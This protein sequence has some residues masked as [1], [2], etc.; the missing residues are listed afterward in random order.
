M[1]WF[2]FLILLL[3]A[4]LTALAVWWAIQKWFRDESESVSE[5]TMQDIHPVTDESE[6]QHALYWNFTTVLISVCTLLLVL[7][8]SVQTMSIRNPITWTLGTA[9]ILIWAMALWSGMLASSKQPAVSSVSSPPELTIYQEQELS[10]T[11]DQNPT[12]ET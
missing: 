4:S 10:S 1:D 2:T 12:E 6:P 8:I 9:L 5:E 3:T 7:G 11:T